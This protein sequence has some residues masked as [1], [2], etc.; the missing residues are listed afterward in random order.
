M[1]SQPPALCSA[2]GSPVTGAYSLSQSHTPALLKSNGLHNGYSHMW[3]ESLHSNKGLY[4]QP[5]L[6]FFR[7]QP[8]KISCTYFVS[9]LELE[10]YCLFSAVLPRSHAAPVPECGWH[11]GQSGDA[12]LGHEHCS[13]QGTSQDL[14]GPGPKAELLSHHGFPLIGHGLQK[15][16]KH[17]T[18]L[19]CSQDSI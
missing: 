6:F 11:Q 10:G 7:R 17:N 18:S 8:L 3:L 5:L 13:N 14:G 1:L 16:T 19:A 4:D 9:V 12:A 15:E 2:F